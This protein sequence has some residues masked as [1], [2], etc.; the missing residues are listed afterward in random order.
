MILEEEL[1]GT[2]FAFDNPN[3]P[4]PINQ[5]PVQA[6]KEKL[7]NG[8]DILLIDVRSQD[9]RAKA[10]IAGSLLW[11]EETMQ[12][13]ESLPKEREII[14]HCHMGGRSLAL[15]DALRRR[16][17]TNLHNLTG[18]IKAWSEEIDPDVPQY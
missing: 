3:A 10:S 17:H 16:G 13:V 15:A 8:E 6:L 2:R 7:D 5:L 14:M 1:T 12:L 18:G 4:P 11:D 9:E